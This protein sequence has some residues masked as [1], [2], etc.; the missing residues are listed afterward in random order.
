MAG[1]KF[2]ETRRER[3]GT[4]A[5]CLGAFLAM[6]QFL[7]EQSISSAAMLFVTV[8]YIAFAFHA[9]SGTW[10]RDASLSRLEAFR[11]LLRLGG[12]MLLQSAPL[13]LV[14]FLAFPRLSTPL[15]GIPA[16][17]SARTGLSE[18]MEPGNISNLSRS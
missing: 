12:I 14:L 11:P 6:T 5:I 2:M 18:H 9:L 16:D 1:L 13:A 8:V 4:L 3:D 10:A 17:H 15:W 7:Y